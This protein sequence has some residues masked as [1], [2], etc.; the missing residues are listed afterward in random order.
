M[1]NQITY[2]V[3]IPGTSEENVPGGNAKAY[4][5]SKTGKKATTCSCVNCNSEAEDGSHVVRAKRNADGK[6]VY[7]PND[8]QYIV[9][10]C[11][12]CNEQEGKLMCVNAELVPAP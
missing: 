9:P 4:W 3:C 5:E 8:P 2:V 12:K 6:W 1:P 11:H 7:N 10:M